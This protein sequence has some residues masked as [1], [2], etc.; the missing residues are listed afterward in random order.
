M[1]LIMSTASQRGKNLSRRDRDG[2]LQ[3]VFTMGRLSFPE[4]KKQSENDEAPLVGTLR[5]VFVMGTTF[6]VLWFLIYWFLLR[7]R[8]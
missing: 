7:S 6:A 5:F 1:V 4:M 8:W 3:T 2:R